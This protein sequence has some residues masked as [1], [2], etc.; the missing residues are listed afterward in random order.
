MHIRIG[1]LAAS[2]LA[3]T[4]QAAGIRTINHALNGEEILAIL[5]NRRDD[6]AN[7]C[8]HTKH[9]QGFSSFSDDQINRLLVHLDIVTAPGRHLLVDNLRVRT[10]LETTTPHADS[11]E[12]DSELVSEHDRTV[13]IFLNDNDHATFVVGNDRIAVEAGKLVIFDGLSRHYT[14][15]LDG[16]VMIAGPYLADGS[17]R[18]VAYI[19]GSKKDGDKSK[20]EDGGED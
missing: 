2:M 7:P 19:R 9:E 3:V 1:F 18:S 13:F 10:L 16:H 12:N 6:G 17:F 5:E 14:E 4:S 15:I 11:K 20:E 8:F